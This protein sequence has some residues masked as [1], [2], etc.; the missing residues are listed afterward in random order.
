MELLRTLHSDNGNTVA[1]FQSDRGFLLRAKTKQ[2]SD[3]SL[4]DFYFD[5]A[6]ADMA[7]NILVNELQ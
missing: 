6:E 3:Y 7:A 5:P 4:L 2:D 1:V